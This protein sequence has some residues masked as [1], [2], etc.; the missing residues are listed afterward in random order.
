MTFRPTALRSGI[1]ALLATLALSAPARAAETVVAVA[2]NFTDAATEIGAAFEK[3][4]GD[5]VTYSFGST[6]QLYTQITQDAPFE[7]FL[8]ADQ[9]RPEKA[10]AEG[11]AVDGSRFTYAVGKLVLY[12]SEAGALD[13]GS[14]ALARPGITHIAIANPVTAP[15]GAAAVEAMKALGLYETLEPK[16][17]QGKSISQTHQFVATGNA[18]LGFVALS[19]VIAEEGGSQW[20]V[21]QEIYTPIR[22]DAVLLTRGADSETARAYLDFLKSPEALAIIGKYGYG[23]ED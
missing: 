14:D 4:T 10:E 22:Q 6:G 8:A 15:Y 18:E 13:D 1:A 2:A 19:Q 3:A 23:T 21:P 16:I 17:V 20:I 5:R 12:S 7:V 9:A 11:H